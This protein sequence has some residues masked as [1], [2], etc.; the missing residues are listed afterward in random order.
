MRRC[1][2][3]LPIMI[4]LLVSCSAK[5]DGEWT[6]NV[7][8]EDNMTNG[9]ELFT[10]NDDSTFGIENNLFF[11]EQKD[12]ISCQFKFSF[13]VRGQ[14]KYE[15]S[16]I[17]LSPDIS[18]FDFNVDEKSFHVKFEGVDSTESIAKTEQSFYKDISSYMEEYYK[19]IYTSAASEGLYLSNV[20]VS[21]DTLHCIC[22]ESHVAWRKR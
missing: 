21:Q 5:F 7:V 10:I 19:Q 20:Y 4:F 8:D 12:N 11:N 3:F 13:S 2:L 22:Q 9:V 14:W 15:N 18:T 17:V 1:F 16:A 6:R